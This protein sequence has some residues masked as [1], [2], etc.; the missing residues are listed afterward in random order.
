MSAATLQSPVYTHAQWVEI[1]MKRFGPNPLRW[2]FVCPVCQHVASVADWK[3]AGAPEGAIAFSCV[4]RF[5]RVARD[6]FDG[7][8][9]GPCNYAGGGLFHLN[10]VR[11]RMANGE[12]HRVFDWAPSEKGGDQ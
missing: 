3:A 4:G 12:I 10:P 7:H 9:A 8:G 2:K 5:Q 11:V 1:C 6:A